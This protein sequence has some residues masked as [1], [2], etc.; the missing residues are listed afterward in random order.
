MK[1]IANMQISAEFNELENR[2]T[3]IFRCN[4]ILITCENLRNKTQSL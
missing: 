2:T 4:V 1:I 3:I